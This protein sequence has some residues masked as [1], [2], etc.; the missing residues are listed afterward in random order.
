MGD[1][2]AEVFAD[3]LGFG[4]GEMEFRQQHAMHRGIEGR[5]GSPLADR[6][7]GGLGTRFDDRFRRRTADLFAL[8]SRVSAR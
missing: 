7:I 4:G 5:G 2:S 6:R 8:S 1:F 3:G